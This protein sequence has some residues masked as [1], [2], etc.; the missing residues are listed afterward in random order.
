MLLL[1]SFFI[2]CCFKGSS[3]GLKVHTNSKTT[4]RYLGQFWI[5]SGS[6]FDSLVHRC[7][8]LGRT[9]GSRL[10]SFSVYVSLQAHATAF[11]ATLIKKNCLLV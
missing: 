9:P 10:Q 7:R 3:M 11:E 1:Y 8:T 4:P 6:N 2:E 5:F